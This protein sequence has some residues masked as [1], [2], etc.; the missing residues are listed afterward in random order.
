MALKYTKLLKLKITFAFKNSDEN[1][2]ICIKTKTP[3]VKKPVFLKLLPNLV[4]ILVTPIRSFY[5]KITKR[6][7]V[8]AL[9]I[10]AATKTLG[11]NKINFRILRMI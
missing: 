2:A 5:G 3:L 8:K 10:Q 11:P 7:V 4:K 6:I 9:M 1:M